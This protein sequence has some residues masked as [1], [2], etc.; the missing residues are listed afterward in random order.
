[1]INKADKNYNFIYFKEF[2]IELIKEKCIALKE[3]WLLDQS[4]QNMQY[5]E[6]RNPHLYTNT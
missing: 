2:N 6:R 1:M 4:R 5:P 3:E